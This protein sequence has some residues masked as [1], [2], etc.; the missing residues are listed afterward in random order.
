MS[1]K[2]LLGAAAVIGL[3]LSGVAL[4]QSQRGAA[5][6]RFLDVIVVLDPALAP[7][8]HAANRAAAGR[9][10]RG[11]GVAPRFRYGSALFGFAGPIPEG[12]LQ[13]LE[14]DPR[15]LYVNFD[16]PVAIP[17]PRATGPK[18]CTTD[19]TL[20]GCSGGGGGGGGSGEEVPWGVDRIGARAN[21]GTGAGVDVYVI[22]T[23]ID[24]DHPDLK[25]H[26][27]EG[28]A[29]TSCR[30]G[31]C[32]ASWDDDHS[33]GTHV[34]G[35]I[36][37]LDNDIDVVGVAPGVT[38][39]A[40]K[41]L[42][43]N[44]SG[45]RSGVI[46]GIDWVAQQVKQA[47]KPAVAN[48]SLGG[49][50]SKTGTCD[51]GGFTGSDSYHEAICTAAHLGVVF[52]VAAG[53]DG[54]D[55]ELAVPAAYDDA[56]ITVTATSNQDDWPSWSNWGNG[57]PTDPIRRRWRSPRPVSTSSRP[58]WAAAPRPRAAPRW[59]RPTSPA[60]SRSTS[61][62]MRRLARQLPCVHRC[63]RVRCWARRSRHPTGSTFSNTS[64]HP[65]GED[66]VDASG[67]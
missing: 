51:T 29:V 38:L 20:P 61:T 14:N 59:P 56:V 21:G 25:T 57:N 18:W 33:H 55:A 48:M 47:G 35:T 45:S 32:K 62:A 52:A 3:A 17:V 9:I 1:P 65:H 34:A 16:A 26:L 40:V 11:L 31:G 22:D 6:D 64:G 58:A 12:R 66:F 41:V 28:Y 23:G 37:A 27:G 4:A 53:N 54:A 36:G 24:A 46:A 2:T 39:H 49:S 30:G 63:A 8:S 7:G 60:R 50:G 13:A 44:G 19:P 15:V 67:L 43:K 42:A 10:A 5:N